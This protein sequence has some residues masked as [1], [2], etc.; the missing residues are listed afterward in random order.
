MD[1]SNITIQ[2]LLGLAIISGSFASTALTKEQWI[3]GIILL[4]VTGGFIFIRE[5][6]KLE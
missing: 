4:L 6:Y 5:Q 2:S 1:V 3:P